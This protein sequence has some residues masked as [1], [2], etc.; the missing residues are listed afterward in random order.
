MRRVRN[1][2]VALVEHARAVVG[3]P[4]TWGQTDCA[5]LA[6]AAIETMYGGLPLD[7]PAY[8]TKTGAL[9]AQKVMS[10]EG[11]LLS[12]GAR[13]VTMRGARAGDILL[14]VGD[15]GHLSGCAYMLSHVAV[16]SS[17]THGVYLRQ[18]ETFE[19]ATMALRLP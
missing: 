16:M 19:D 6:I 18:R 1:W 13:W 15:L 17:E 4:F 10:I 11:G 8:T 12:L 2:D 14:A 5:S 7:L 3:S 9:R